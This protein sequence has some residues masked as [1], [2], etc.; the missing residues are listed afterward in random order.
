MWKNTRLLKMIKL[1]VPETDVFRRNKHE[2][3]PLVS[4]LSFKNPNNEE[5][6]GK[7]LM[8]ECSLNVGSPNFQSELINSGLKLFE[9][10]REYFES[11]T[12]RKCI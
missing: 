2:L 1:C 11:R 3:L 8:L 12:P 4:G 9:T 6:P 7:E 10:I 5:Y